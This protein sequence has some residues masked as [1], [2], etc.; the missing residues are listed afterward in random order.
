M[1]DDRGFQLASHY[2]GE[3]RYASRKSAHQ[4]LE[5]SMI[6]ESKRRW[7]ID[8]HDHVLCRIDARA[9]ATAGGTLTKM[10]PLIADARS[11]T[12]QHLT[13]RTRDVRV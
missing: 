7:V 9:A 12:M 3:W 10:K 5:L 6:V 13:H 2:S 8:L 4:A 1:D 11:A